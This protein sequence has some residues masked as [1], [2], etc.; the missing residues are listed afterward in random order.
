MGTL[1][2]LPPNTVPRLE[3]I[4]SIIT[5][6]PYQLTHSLTYL[7]TCFCSP[8]QMSAHT[9]NDEIRRDG[10]S[11]TNITNE[12][13][14]EQRMNCTYTYTCTYTYNDT[15]DRN[16]RDEKEE[17]EKKKMM[18]SPNITNRSTLMDGNGENDG[19][20][21]E[22]NDNARD[23]N[24]CCND[25][26]KAQEAAKV[27]VTNIYESVHAH[28]SSV[29]EDYMDSTKDVNKK[30]DR[31]C[32]DSNAVYRNGNSNNI[33]SKNSSKKRMR[34]SQELEGIKDTKYDTL[35][36]SNLDKRRST[37]I[38]RSSTKHVDDPALTKKSATWLDMYE[39]LKRYKSMHGHCLVPQQGSK[40][41][42]WGECQQKM[43]V[44]I[45]YFNLILFILRFKVNHQRDAYRY[46]KINQSCNNK[47]TEEQIKA[48][49][50][51]GFVWC[52]TE[53]KVSWEDKF[54]E[55]ECY[56]LKFGDCLV[57][58]KG[59]AGFESLGR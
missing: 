4:S 17:V 37:V 25:R 3:H 45:E 26:V 11:A 39:E 53:K 12:D 19:V 48:L 56:K 50:E 14:T 21:E 40:L 47:I 49:N 41:G 9:D 15:D 29:T 7:L 6:V 28:E 16:D 58:K 44:S 43:N 22:G 42:K 5:T 51:I 59:V 27:M 20:F 1:P 52:V 38:V 2:N 30:K 32:D 18:D 57:P 10:G 36:D 13:D 8:L 35:Q 34:Q 24:V 55:L 54:E 23:E 31:I 33:E 46:K